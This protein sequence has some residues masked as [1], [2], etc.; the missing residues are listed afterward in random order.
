MS[1]RYNRGDVALD[2][3][4]YTSSDR[5]DSLESIPMRPLRNGHSESLD[6]PGSPQPA[7]ERTLRKG[8]F[9]YREY[10][11]FRFFRKFIAEASWGRISCQKI[12]AASTFML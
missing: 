4:S 10:V 8:P 6:D 2:A 12:I 9:V 3:T 7:G 5:H 1:P 11:S